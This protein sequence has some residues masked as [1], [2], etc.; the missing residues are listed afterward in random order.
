[1]YRDIFRDVPHS[2]FELGHKTVQENRAV[3]SAAFGCFCIAAGVMIKCFVVVTAWWHMAEQQFHERTIVGGIVWPVPTYVQPFCYEIEG[4][5]RALEEHNAIIDRR[6]MM[7]CD[8]DI[9]PVVDPPAK[10]NVYVGMYHHDIH[11]H[12]HH[13]LTILKRLK[14]QLRFEEVDLVGI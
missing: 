1:M 14:E 6:P 2:R 11:V 12:P 13:P 4:P 10:L 5:R 9:K 8:D 3:L 7:V